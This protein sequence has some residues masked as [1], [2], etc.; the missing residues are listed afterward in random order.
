MDSKM[1]VARQKGLTGDD[2]K[3]DMKEGLLD[4]SL[5]MQVKHLIGDRKEGTKKEGLLDPSLTPHLTGEGD[6]SEED[7]D[8][9]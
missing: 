7:K 5:T 4:S 9:K 2:R 3:E 1:E 6:V 8:K